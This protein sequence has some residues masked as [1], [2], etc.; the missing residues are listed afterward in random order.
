MGKFV[1]VE[2]PFVHEMKFAYGV[3]QQVA[4]NIRRIVAQNPSP[5]TYFGT[6]TYIVGS[7][8]VAVIDPGPADF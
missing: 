3:A 4:P 7:G 1:T 6:G 5:F 2:I 8:K